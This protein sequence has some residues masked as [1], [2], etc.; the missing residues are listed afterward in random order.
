MS[1]ARS[2]LFVAVCSV[3]VACG[4]PSESDPSASST[5]SGGTVSTATGGGVATTG[6][7][8]S[9]GSSSDGGVGTGGSGAGPS[10]GGSDTGSGGLAIPVGGWPDAPTSGAA[11]WVRARNLCPF[12]LWVRAQ[13]AEATLQP[14]DAQLDTNEVVDFASPATWTAARVT[15]FKDG[16]GQGE[17]EKAEMTIGN[18]VLN[19]NVTYVDWVGLPMEIVGVGSGCNDQNHTTGCWAKE[20]ELA[21]GCPHDFLK[22]NGRCMSPRS[23]CA[24]PGHQGEDY[25]HALDSA[26]ASCGQCPKASTPEVYACNGPYQEEPRLCAALNRGISQN[27][28]DTDTSH[29]YQAAPYNDYAKWVHDVCPDIYAFSYDDWQSQGGFRAC[30]G[31]ELRITF[32][33]GG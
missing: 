27:P 28:D 26:I 13:G 32:C 29:F 31:N 10:S 7:T 12:P 5:A 21:S 16:P 1:I 33:P 8:T 24:N 2:T 30:S 15:A 11:V 3:P 23:Y 4:A 9:G 14:A 20:S 6:G 18:G 25:C 17:I 22:D 19:Y